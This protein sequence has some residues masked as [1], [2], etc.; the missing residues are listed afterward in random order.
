MK[1]GGF[2][3]QIL[4]VDLST[5]SISKEPLEFDLAA[6]YLGGF[7]VDLKLL[8]DLLPCGTD[9]LAPENPIIFGAGPLIGTM[10]PGSSKVTFTAKR[11]LYACD[12]EVKKHGVMVGTGGTSRFGF[13]FKNAGYDH[14][15]ITGRADKP[16]FLKIV[17]DKVEIHD[18]TDFWGKMNAYETTLELTKRYGRCGIYAIGT[19][20]ENLV[21]ISTGT[22]DGAYS[23]GKAGGAAI[24][25]S[26]NLKAI[27]IYGDKGIAVS[28]RK[29]FMAAYYEGSRRFTKNPALSDVARYGL[30]SVG[31]LAHL[32]GR[33]W[34]SFWGKHWKLIDK[35]RVS[36]LSC[37]S[38]LTPCRSTMKIEDGRFSGLTLVRRSFPL[39]SPTRPPTEGLS[40]YG[41]GLVVEDRIE[42][43]GLDRQN[44]QQ[45]VNYMSLLFERGEITKQD[46]DGLTLRRRD[47]WDTDIDSTIQLIERMANREGDFAWCLG[48]GWYPIA[49]RF[50]VNPFEEM[51]ISK[52]ASCI[53][54]A[55][56]VRLHPSVFANITCPGVH[57]LHYAGYY[58]GLPVD[59]IKANGLEMGMTEEQMLRTFIGEEFDTGRLLKHVEDYYALL[60]SLGICAL[61]AQ[62]HAGF[63]INLI[64]EYYSALTG[65]ETSRG[66]LK[67]LGEKVWNLYKLLNVREGFKRKDDMILSW[68]NAAG[69]N[70]LDYWGNSISKKNLEEMLDHYYSERGWDIT[71]GIPSKEII[72]DL[73]LNE[74]KDILPN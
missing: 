59:E 17:N 7:G 74:F 47:Y 44:A 73:Q 37:I 23:L 49:K 66:E 71:A 13:M 8:Y 31:A 63:D 58:P 25:G 62:L 24:M 12:P 67:I 19:A 57:H 69:H 64:A 1:Q 27:V 52:G 2:I 65:F 18:A 22:I 42:R 5:R 46:A 40:D 20:G 16:V 10:A 30:I 32:P 39:S 34:R 56:K 29:R 11:P 70:L 68:W 6:K 4:Y 72:E 54:D 43:L 55:R 21:R 45:I 33:D 36:N 51:A 14:I 26:K 50:G 15:V 35:T 3:G 41:P 53:L 28:N 9:P 48:E 60:N 38:C 61:P